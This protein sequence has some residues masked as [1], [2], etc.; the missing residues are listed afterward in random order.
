MR[1]IDDTKRIELELYKDIKINDNRYMTIGKIKD[2]YYLKIKDFT[3]KILYEYYL[4][5]KCKRLSTIN[6]YARCYGVEF[7]EKEVEL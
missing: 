4:V 3:N 7:Y 5:E 2:D 6:K 1:I